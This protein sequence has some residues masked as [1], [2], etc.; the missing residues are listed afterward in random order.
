MVKDGH[1]SPQ[2]EVLKGPAKAHGGDL[3]RFKADDGFAVQQDITFG[4]PVNA[5]DN[6]EDGSLACSIGSDQ[7]PDLAGLKGQIVI[8]DGSQPTEVMAHFSYLEQ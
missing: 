3:V 5:A 2:T 8:V 6:V 1:M 4:G 7:T